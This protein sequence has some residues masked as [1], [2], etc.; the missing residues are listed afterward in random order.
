[1]PDTVGFLAVGIVDRLRSEEH[2]AAVDP[3]AAPGT[4]E[5]DVAGGHRLRVVGACDPEVPT[6]PIRGLSP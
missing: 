2:L 6:R 5:I 4:I 3:R 1:M